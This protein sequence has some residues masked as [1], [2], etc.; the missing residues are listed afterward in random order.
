MANTKN[1][2]Q[3]ENYENMRKRVEAEDAKK[4][5]TKKPTTKKTTDTKKTK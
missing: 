1:Q 4:K 5:E 2:I 3:W